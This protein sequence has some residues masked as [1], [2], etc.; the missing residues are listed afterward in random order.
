MIKDAIQKVVGRESL[1]QEEAHAAMGQIMGG[2]ATPAQIA[3]FIV[4]LRMKGET[5]DEIVG[6]ARAMREHA[7]RINPR[8]NHLVD[9][10]GTGGDRMNTFNIST[11]SAFVAA[12]AG[13]HVAKHGNRAVS[14]KCGSAD[15]LEALGVGLE[16]EPEAV[17]AC[18]ERERIGFL[19]APRFH[20]AMRHA[21]GPRREVGIRTVFNILG[22][23]TN[24]AGA[25]NQVLGVY[26][27]S[28]VEIMAEVLAGLGAER[29]FVVHGMDGMDEMTTTGP[30]KVAEVRDGKIYRY[31]LE[32]EQVDLPRAAP[33]A[34]RG[35]SPQDNVKTATCVLTGEPGPGRDVVLLN[36]GAALVAAGLAE[37]LKEGAH[38]AGKSIDSGEAYARLMGLR[39]RTTTAAE[40]KS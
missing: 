28:L 31:T 20:L 13:A 17:Q 29:A 22:P 3:A 35:G 5:V 7:V 37:D 9:T 10:C 21:V 30:T 1:T 12:G 14:S 39:A 26:D 11:V 15:L 18:I 2:E 40:Q 23:L 33:E 34:L 8:V 36:A 24:P 38:L 4:A 27:A 16:V 25:R 6:F 19:F 32:P